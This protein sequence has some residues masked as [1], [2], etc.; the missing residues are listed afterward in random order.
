L[1]INRKFKV[2]GIKGQVICQIHDQLVCQVIDEDVERACE[3]VQ[4]CMENTTKLDGVELIAIPEV[5]KNF[6]DGH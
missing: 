4:D 2:E 1:Q 3:I 6:R 5:A